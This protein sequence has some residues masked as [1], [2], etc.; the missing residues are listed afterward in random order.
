MGHKN[1]LV[2]LQWL[3]IWSIN[4]FSE[5]TKI[6]KTKLSKPLSLETG[7]NG[8]SVWLL[9]GLKQHLMPPSDQHRH[10]SWIKIFLMLG[11]KNFPWFCFSETMI[12]NYCSPGNEILSKLHKQ[13]ACD[14]SIRRGLCSLTPSLGDIFRKKLEKE[15]TES[16]IDPD[17][18]LIASDSELVEIHYIV[19]WLHLRKIQVH[20]RRFHTFFP[21]YQPSVFS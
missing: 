18:I 15:G 1:I 12:G 8:I 6:T 20:S 5:E 16:S 4:I 11:Q 14:I 3:K 7:L 9:N 2:E 17:Y 10:G 19:P 13:T 21:T